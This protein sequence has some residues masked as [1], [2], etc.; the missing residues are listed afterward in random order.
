MISREDVDCVRFI[1]M[2]L[3]VHLSH[4]GERAINEILSRAYSSFDS[5]S[6]FGSLLSSKAFHTPVPLTSSVA[7]A[8][9]AIVSIAVLMDQ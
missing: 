7:P 2:H 8:A 4:H 9:N 3:A 6:S 5:S 1:Q